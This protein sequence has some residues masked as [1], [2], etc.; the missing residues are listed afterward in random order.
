M[1][2]NYE[3]LNFTVVTYDFNGNMFAEN[4]D[5]KQHIEKDDE[6]TRSKSDEGNV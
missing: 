5:I 6:T 2:I 3:A 1:K 4:V